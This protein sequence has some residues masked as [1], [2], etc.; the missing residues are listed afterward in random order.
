MSAH[1]NI[2]CTFQEHKK[3]VNMFTVVLQILAFLLDDFC[4]DKRATNHPEISGPFGKI[5]FRSSLYASTSLR[6]TDFISLTVRLISDELGLNRNSVWQ[7]ITEDLGMRK[8]CTM[9][10]P[11]LLNDDQKMRHRQVCQ[12]ILENFD[13]NPDFL[14]KVMTGCEI[15]V[16]S[17]IQ[18]PNV[19]VLNH[20]G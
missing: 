6:R 19:R 9:M 10:V 5:P 12:D 15:W 16:L 4:D 11:K 2:Y 8:V 13:S 17:M 20:Y 14:K 1:W 3:I 7:I 18:R